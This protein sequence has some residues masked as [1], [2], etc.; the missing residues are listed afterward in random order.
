MEISEDRVLELLEMQKIA[1]MTSM[2]NTVGDDDTSLSELLGD[3]D[4]GYDDVETRDLLKRSMAMLDREEQAILHTR[5]F[6]RIN[7]KGQSRRSW[8]Y[9]RCTFPKEKKIL[10]KMRE[11]IRKSGAV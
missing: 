4:R 11:T 10:A 1:T 6:G 8:A 3:A 7:P 2:D 5:G 9:R